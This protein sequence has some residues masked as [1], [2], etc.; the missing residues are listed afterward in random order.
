MGASWFEDGRG[1]PLRTPRHGPEGSSELGDPV[2]LPRAQG[3][4][5]HPLPRPAANGPPP[6]RPPNY[7]SSTTSR[8]SITA[9]ACT[10]ASATNLLWS[11]KPTSATAE[12]NP[13]RKQPTALSASSKK[14]QVVGRVLVF[15]VGILIGSALHAIWRGLA[16][17]K[18]AVVERPLMFGALLAAVHRRRPGFFPRQGSLGHCPSCARAKAVQGEPRV[19]RSTRNI[20]RCWGCVW[21][22]DDSG[23]SF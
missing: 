12:T 3:R 19:R 1:P 20:L 11:S 18:Q 5:G 21:H 4:R 2:P 9:P 6:G 8:A 16:K 10:A 15:I 23:F 22:G 17:V 14:D 7:S 13:Q